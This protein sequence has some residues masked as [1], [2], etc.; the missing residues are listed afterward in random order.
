[1]QNLWVGG[2]SNAPSAFRDSPTPPLPIYELFLVDNH[3]ENTQILRIDASNNIFFKRG[4][5][6]AD[7]LGVVAP[8]FVPFRTTLE[9]PYT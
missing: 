7:L 3:K 5:L 2:G 1:L 4:L 6:S 8:L 9:S